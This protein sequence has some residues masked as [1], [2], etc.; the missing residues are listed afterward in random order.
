MDKNN[1][2]YEFIDCE[3]GQ[4]NGIESFPTL[5]SSDGEKLSGYHEV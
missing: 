4:C 3:K 2:A 1:K 5:V